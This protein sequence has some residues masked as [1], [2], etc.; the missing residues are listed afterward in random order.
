MEKLRVSLKEMDRNDLP[1]LIELWHTPEIMRYAD[2]FPSMRGWSK[3]DDV[4]NAWK[5]YQAHR[6]KYGNNYT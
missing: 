2:E 5:K 4:D 6:A 1:F 3:S